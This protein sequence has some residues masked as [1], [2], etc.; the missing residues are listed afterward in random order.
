V[1]GGSVEPAELA[2]EVDETGTDE[3]AWTAEEDP[4]P[5]GATVDDDEETAS[6]PELD[7]EVPL[8]SG[9]GGHAVMQRTHASTVMRMC[10]V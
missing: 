2:S 6:A 1:H 9:S 5:L 4:P 3:D 8:P 7:D 10:A